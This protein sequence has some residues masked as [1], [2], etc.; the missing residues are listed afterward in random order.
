MQRPS[1]WLDAQWGAGGLPEVT[2]VPGK[3]LSVSGSG[4]FSLWRRADWKSSREAE[5]PVLSEA[6]CA[7]GVQGDKHP[8][9][10]ACQ[11]LT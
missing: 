6:S 3:S 1:Q 2:T 11:T 10:E 7:S 9:T 8:S 4:S 5:Q